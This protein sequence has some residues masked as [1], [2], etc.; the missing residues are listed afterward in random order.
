MTTISVSS[1]NVKTNENNC[2]ST[3][4]VFCIAREQAELI[5]NQGNL[6]VSVHTENSEEVGR[7][8]DIF[9]S[10]GAQDICATGEASTSK[11]GKATRR[12]S[13]PDSQVVRV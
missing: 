8:K 6:L 9:A 13:H 11:T 4:S 2:M 7:A 10:T 12:A 5:I 1:Q 3:K